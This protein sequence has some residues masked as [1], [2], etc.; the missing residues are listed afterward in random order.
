[1]MRLL[2]GVYL[3]NTIA[4]SEKIFSLV[5]ITFYSET[6]TLKVSLKVRIFVV[7]NLAQKYL[8]KRINIHT[9]LIPRLRSR[10]KNKGRFIIPLKI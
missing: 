3:N 8:N 5:S 9:F 2:V 1:M 10:S 6:V 4:N 7:P